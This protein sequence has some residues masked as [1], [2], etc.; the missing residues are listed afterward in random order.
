MRWSVTWLPA[1]EAAL[2]DIWMNTSDRAAV[3]AAADR[4][5]DALERGPLG[6]GESRVHNTRILIDLPLGVYYEVD[7]TR[8]EVEVFAVFLIAGPR[9]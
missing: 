5:D 8:H 3:T 4:I 1:A 7:I 2:A 9:P 6:A